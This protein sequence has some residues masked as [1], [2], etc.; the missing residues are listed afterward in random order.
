MS[1]VP[2]SKAAHCRRWYRIELLY[3][4]LF[5]NIDR[6]SIVDRLIRSVLAMFLEK[7]AHIGLDPCQSSELS[8]GNILVRPLKLIPIYEE[9]IALL[10][11]VFIHDV[12]SRNITKS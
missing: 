1:W 2:W 3:S 6:R 9:M 5:I 7:N 11:C 8:P 12:L 4:A 10:A